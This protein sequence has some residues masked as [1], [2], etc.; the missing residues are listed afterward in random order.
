[1]SR[2]LFVCTGN[3]CRSPTAAALLVARL[4]TAGENAE[5][6]SAG[7][8]QSGVDVPDQVVEAGRLVGIDLAG[9][10]SRRMNREDVGGADLLL[11][12][13]REHVRETVAL[14][15][16]AW[17]KTFTLL[18]LVRRGR[19]VGA[20][21]RREDLVDWLAV[22]GR[23][24]RGVDLLGSS[25]EDDIADPM[26]GPP[27]AYLDAARTIA[28]ALDQLVPLLWAPTPRH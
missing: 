19:L 15:E 28:G 17:P 21:G 20:Q 25:P 18:E 1:V 16:N 7:L 23:G 10:Q 24:R 5:I 13:T 4:E 2:I 9:H 8:L 11:G 22:V 6:G 26:G 12:M 14:D 27:K 3:L